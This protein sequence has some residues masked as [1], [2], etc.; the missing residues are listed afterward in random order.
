MGN[1]GT[2]KKQVE[3]SKKKKGCGGTNQFCKWTWKRD[4][5]SPFLIEKFVG[6]VNLT[7]LGLKMGGLA[8]DQLKI[9]SKKL[10]AEKCRVFFCNFV[11]ISVAFRRNS[12]RCAKSVKFV[13]IFRRNLDSFSL[14]VRTSEVHRQVK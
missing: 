4:V 9:I 2:P 10:V 11:E 13:E 8:W 3:N 14:I 7:I 1:L 5:D 12:T 6:N